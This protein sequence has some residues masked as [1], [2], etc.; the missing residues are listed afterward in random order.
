MK[1]WQKLEIAGTITILL[2]AFVQLFVLDAVKGANWR[3]HI[4]AIIENQAHARDMVYEL[5]NGN[6]DKLQ[7]L[8]NIRGR[9]SLYSQVSEPWL[10]T[11]ANIELL[12][13]APFIVGSA[14]LIIAKTIQYCGDHRPDE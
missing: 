14:L 10:N 3:S 6:S 1:T 4:G 13:A 12:A 2:S 8:A 7:T 11:L 9:A 5:A